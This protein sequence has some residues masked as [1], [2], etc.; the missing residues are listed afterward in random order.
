VS[1]HWRHDHRRLVI[2]IAGNFLPQPLGIKVYAAF[3]DF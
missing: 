2:T 1:R 3:F